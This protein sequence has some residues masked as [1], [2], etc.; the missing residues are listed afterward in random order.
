MAEAGTVSLLRRGLLWLAGLTTVAL[1]IELAAERHWTQPVQWIAWVALAVTLLGIILVLGRPSQT[2]IQIARVL[3][4][5]VIVS[6]A[7]GIWEHID[8]NYD[9]G[10]L[11]RE[12][13]EQ[14]ESLPVSTKWWLAVSKTVGPSPPLAPGA[15]A[16]AGVCIL[17]VT[18][19]H[20]ALRDSSTL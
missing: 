13:S 19:R 10:E 14:W 4:V 7:V 12:Y 16:Q 8:S 18:L 15:L 9:A 11:D 17:L 3:A 1:G 6:A 20:P 2:R 5:L